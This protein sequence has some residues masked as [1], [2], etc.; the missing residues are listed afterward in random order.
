MLLSKVINIYESSKITIIGD[1]INFIDKDLDEKR[2]TGQRKVKMKKM[3]VK[4]SKKDIDNSNYMYKNSADYSFLSDDSNQ[5]KQKKNKFKKIN[6][7]IARSNN[8]IIKLFAKLI[9]KPQFFLSM[10]FVWEDGQK[11]MPYDEKHKCIINFIEKIHKQY[12]ESWFI[13]IADF[14]YKIGVH[15]HVFC[16]IQADVKQRKLKNELKKHGRI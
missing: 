16:R 9:I 3:S 15:F 7:S 5:Y 4:L 11:D 6:K 14:G 10:S 12:P 8:N 13:P 2:S 1:S